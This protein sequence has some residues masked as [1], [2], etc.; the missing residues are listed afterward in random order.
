MCRLLDGVH[1]AEEVIS[2]LAGDFRRDEVYAILVDLEHEGFI[3]ECSLA[4]SPGVLDIASVLDVNPKQVWEALRSKPVR[5]EALGIDPKPFQAIL[6]DLDI[7]IGSDAVVTVVLA[8]DYLHPDLES[9]NI[10]ALRSRHPW[11]LLQASGDVPL[12]GPLFIPGKTACWACLAYRLRQNRR[13]ESF[14]KHRKGLVPPLLTREA[15]PS[16]K[17]V[18][19]SMAAWEL[20]KWLVVGKSERLEGQFVSVDARTWEPTIHRVRRLRTCPLCGQSLEPRDGEPA[21][22][23]LT[24]RPR[25]YSTDGGYRTRMPSEAFD[26]YKHLIDPRTE[27]LRNLQRLDTPSDSLIHTYTINH[28]LV[29]VID[30]LEKLRISEQGGSSGKG[31]TEAQAK[32][33]ALFEALE[34]FS[35]VWQGDEYHIMGSY[36]DLKPKALHPC[37]LLGF[38]ESQYASRVAWNAACPSISLYIPVPFDESRRIA[39][40]PVRSPTGNSLH[41][42][43]AVYGYFGY[44]DQEDPFCYGDSNGNAA[45]ITL[46]EAILQGFFEVVE[47][48]AVAIWFY[49]RLRRPGVDLASFEDPYYT[50]LQRYYRQFLHRD[51]WV[52]DVTT[53]L[54]V[55][56]FVAVSRRT[57]QLPEDIIMGFGCHLDPRIAVGRALTELN[58]SLHNVLERHEGQ[59]RYLVE[60]PVALEWLQTAT[61]EKHPYLA[62]DPHQPPKITGAYPHLGSGDLRDDVLG[63][64]LRAEQCG[65]DVYVLN[66]TRE[67]IGL[68][69][70]KVVV[71]GLVHFWRRFGHRRLYE[72]PVQMGWLRRPLLENELNPSS[73]VL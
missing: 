71:P 37:Q 41:Y 27:M 42:L 60:D 16:L 38:S 52:L 64:A 39:W 73:I 5:I 61:L 21:P 33:S 34:R 49:N 25:V 14:L 69:V 67:D 58:Q 30:T 55:P 72:V 29:S 35:S 57:D 46:E 47:R 24:S 62:P 20:A 26:Q 36:N 9:F 53:D 13:A 54:D 65:L 6:S 3:V 15:P 32:A 50:D 66:L 4:Q 63:C 18:T 59:T 2:S 17:A 43:P 19:F 45:G 31:K 70:V 56:S 68:P 10:K 48:D 28:S 11:M 40:V 8:I 23:V 12:I 22:L 51:L 7:Q 1:T 44:P